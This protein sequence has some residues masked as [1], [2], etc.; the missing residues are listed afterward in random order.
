[1]YIPQNDIPLLNVEMKAMNLY[2]KP[3]RIAI[4]FSQMAA[5][6]AKTDFGFDMQDQLA[7]QAV[8]RLSYEIDTETTQLLAK[9]AFNQGVA[10]T[11]DRTQPIGVSKM[12]HYAGFAEILGIANQVIYDRTK[13]FAANWMMIASDILPILLLVPGFTAAPAGTVNGPYFAGTIG[14]L[15]VFVTP[16]LKAGEFVVGVKGDDLQSAAA[17]YAPYMPIVPT[18]LLQ[19][20]DGG[21]SQGFSTLYD[22]KVLNPLLVVAGQ[23][24]GTSAAYG[25]PYAATVAA[26]GLNVTQL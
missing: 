14:Q 18:Q 21:T 5:F 2:A 25:Q 1:M 7:Q 26:Q 6:Q 20:A 8:G 15:K 23:V 10:V 22:L 19:Y 16:E 12:E 9:T 24:T 4:Y 11:W 13:R 3:R 17:V